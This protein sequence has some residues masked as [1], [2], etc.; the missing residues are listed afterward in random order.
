MKDR[1]FTLVSNLET[2]HYHEANWRGR[3]SGDPGNCR[4]GINYEENLTLCR[5]NH[6]TAGGWPVPTQ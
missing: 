4:A 5:E 2:H 3:V 1:F 6:W